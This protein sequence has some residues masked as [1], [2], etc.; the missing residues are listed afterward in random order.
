MGKRVCT[1][2]SSI[3]LH[4]HT[5]FSG[6]SSQKSKGRINSHLMHHPML[7]F[8]FSKHPNHSRQFL[9]VHIMMCSKLCTLHK[10]SYIKYQ[11]VN[12]VK[13]WC[14]IVERTWN[15]SFYNLC[16]SAADTLR[17]HI[18]RNIHVMPRSMW[19]N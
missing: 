13:L 16:F 1:L 4:I 17:S 18:G 7:V 14:S 15:E 2:S 9:V 12:H 19:L 3:C 11:L 5:T 6:F 10:L 8:S